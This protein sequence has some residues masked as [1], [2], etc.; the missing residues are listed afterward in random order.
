MVNFW[1]SLN[2]LWT[3]KTYNYYLWVS[4]IIRVV[5]KQDIYYLFIYLFI[6]YL[7]CVLF[8]YLLLK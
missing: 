3:N 2:L 7:S 4:E 5:V 1:K 6:D 8:I